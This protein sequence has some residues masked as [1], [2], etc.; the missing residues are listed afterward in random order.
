LIKVQQP[1]IVCFIFL[2][3]LSI[4]FQFLGSIFV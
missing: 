1:D 4:I 3:I 2:I